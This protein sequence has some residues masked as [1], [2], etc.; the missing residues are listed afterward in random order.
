MQTPSAQGSN[1]IRD[2]AG[3]EPT[4]GEGGDT[5]TPARGGSITPTQG[6]PRNASVIFD[7]DSQSL[8]GFRRRTVGSSQRRRHHRIESDL[9]EESGPNTG[10][11]DNVFTETHTPLPR[12]HQ[13]TGVRTS[14]SG[15]QRRVEPYSD[16]ET[17]AGGG[18]VPMA[19]S[20]S[21]AQH[22]RQHGEVRFVSF[23]QSLLL[24]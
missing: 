9:D 21:G 20:S 8:R 1:I 3:R 11:G 16:E 15:K 2:E 17:G 13:N 4:L 12:D 18:D 10:N 7:S 24:T 19:E 5:P 14:R 23:L 22:Q 6:N